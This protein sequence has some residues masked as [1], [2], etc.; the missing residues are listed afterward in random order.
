MTSRYRDPHW[1]GAIEAAETLDLSRNRVMTFLQNQ[2]LN[3]EDKPSA[4]TER[5]PRKRVRRAEFQAWLAN[6]TLTG[7]DL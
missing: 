6:R 5:G 1:V 2:G 7:K 3:V 4:G